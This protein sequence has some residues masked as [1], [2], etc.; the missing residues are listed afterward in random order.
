MMSAPSSTVTDTDSLTCSDRASRNGCAI[1][2]MFSD[3]R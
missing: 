3:D 2:W 1:C